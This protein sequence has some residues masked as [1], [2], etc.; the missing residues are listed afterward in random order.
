MEII[1]LKDVSSGTGIHLHYGSHNIN[2]KRYKVVHVGIEDGVCYAVIK[3]FRE[4]KGYCGMKVIYEYEWSIFPYYLIDIENVD[5]WI[6][7][8]NQSLQSAFATSK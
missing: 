2:N 5:E 3:F 7:G 8:D 4:S 6:Q 1:E